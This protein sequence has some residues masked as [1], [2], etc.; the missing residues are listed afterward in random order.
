MTRFDFGDDAGDE[1]DLIGGD[2]S[3]EDGITEEF[4]RQQKLNNSSNADN[5]GKLKQAKLWRRRQYE[6]ALT[7]AACNGIINFLYIARIFK[8][9]VSFQGNE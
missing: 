2:R 7:M 1:L 8:I 6:I 9:S 5:D 4:E 3:N